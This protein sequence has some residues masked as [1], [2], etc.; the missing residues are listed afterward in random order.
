MP[1]GIASE[2]KTALTAEYLRSIAQ[3]DA[4]TGEFYA[5]IRTRKWNVGDKLGYVRPDGYIA[6]MI[7]WRKFLCHRLAWFYVHG[8]WPSKRLDHINRDRTDNR[9][10]NLREA[11]GSQNGINRNINTNNTSGILGVCW[12]KGESKWMAKIQVR[13]RTI[14]LGRFD[15]LADAAVARDRAEIKYYGRFARAA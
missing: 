14:N 10:S 15:S 7:D 11:T 6:F 5:R 12:D 8:V 9:I 3:Y 13:G 1:K 2:H 4:E